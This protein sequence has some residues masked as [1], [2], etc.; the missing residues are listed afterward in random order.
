MGMEG[1]EWASPLWPHA[2]KS[3]CLGP[4]TCEGIAI[5]PQVQT[6][7]LCVPSLVLK[8][9]HSL[10]GTNLETDLKQCEKGQRCA[11]GIL[12]GVVVRGSSLEAAAPQLG[13]RGGE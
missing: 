9:A 3:T 10:V 2:Y 4:V 13:L 5:H 6:V 7:P 8:G 1:T 11:G 12:G